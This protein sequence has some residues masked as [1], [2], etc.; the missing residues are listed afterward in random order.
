[1][2]SNT[3][4]ID[5]AS[6]NLN[7]GASQENSQ[8]FPTN[9]AGLNPLVSNVGAYIYSNQIVQFR[10]NFKANVTYYIKGITTFI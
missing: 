4:N 6:V 8:F 7:T 5:N 9:L 3:L 2:A 10:L 1:L